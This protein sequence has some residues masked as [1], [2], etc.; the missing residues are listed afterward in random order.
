MANR[1]WLPYG[2]SLLR[3]LTDRGTEYCGKHDEH[4]YE[5]Y[6]AIN[7]IEHTK[8]K[9]RSPQQNGIC[10]RFHRTIL[11]NFYQPALRRKIYKSLE[12]LQADLDQW[13]HHYNFERTHQG[14]MCC[15]RTPMATWLDGLSLA[16]E[17]QLSKLSFQ[18]ETHGHT[19]TLG[20]DVVQGKSFSEREVA[21]A[22]L[23]N[24]EAESYSRE[25]QM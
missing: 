13:L 20:E 11:E 8:T 18:P 21:I 24:V 6:L 22:T 25:V 15:G 17:K 4:E 23:D 12:E 7:D 2:I 16:K 19:P 1:L 9:V 14:K 10:E 3:A 5:L